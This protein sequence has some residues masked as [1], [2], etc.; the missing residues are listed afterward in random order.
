M[1]KVDE[2]ESLFLSSIKE[3]YHHETLSFRSVLLVTDLKSDAANQLLLE[4]K[5]FCNNIVKESVIEWKILLGSDFSSAGSLLGSVNEVDVDLI[6]TYRNLHSE[7]WRHPF[8]LGEQ[9]DVLLQKTQTPVLV[10]PHPSADFSRE[11]AL[12]K[13]ASVLVATDH[14][15]NNH[16]LIQHGL[17]FVEK[18]CQIFLSHVEDQAYFDRVINSIAKIPTIETKEVETKL[19]Q[20][21]LKE[22]LE[23]IESVKLELESLGKEYSVIPIVKF[24]HYIKDYLNLIEENKIGLLVINTKDGEQMAMHGLAYPLAIEIRQIPILML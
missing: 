9:L 6:V 1:L 24:G 7:T 11:H 23:Y 17:A 15:V 12:D 4:V 2:F 20:Q 22:P 14:L 16:R 19:A 13:C 18:N 3:T 10:I 21:L 8:S 5:K